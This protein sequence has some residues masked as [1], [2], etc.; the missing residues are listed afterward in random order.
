MNGELLLILSS[1]KNALGDMGDKTS[2]DK[3]C[4]AIYGV[5]QERCHYINCIDCIVGYKDSTQYAHKIIQTWKI[6]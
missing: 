6:L 5:D 4:D 2:T 1:I 3:L